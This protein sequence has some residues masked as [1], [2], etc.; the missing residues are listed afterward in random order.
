MQGRWHRPGL[1]VFQTLCYTTGTPHLTSSL[2]DASNG[3]G[4]CQNIMMPPFLTLEYSVAF[5]KLNLQNIPLIDRLVA[6][7]WGGTESLSSNGHGHCDFSHSHRPAL[8][9]RIY[10]T[11]RRLDLPLATRT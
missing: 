7:D 9:T 4:S 8:A 1:Y 5:N 11:Q 3:W 10:S 2:K 6:M